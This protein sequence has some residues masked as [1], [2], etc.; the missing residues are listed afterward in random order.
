MPEELSTPRLTLRPLQLSDAARTQL[1]FPHWEIV[2]FLSAVVPWPFPQD[3]AMKYYREQA[4]PA[5]E[6]GDEWHWT[7]RLKGSPEEHI[8]AI[9][10]FRG[11]WDNRGFWMGMPWQGQ[12]LMTE[13]VAA[14]SEYWF[15]TLGFDRLR[16]PKAL[17]NVGSARISEKTGMRVIAECEREYVSGRLPS[18]IWEITA[19]EWRRQRATLG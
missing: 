18:R 6:R 7:I 17:A 10:L 11:E 15:G 8:G 13:A 5:I 14:A 1:L 16:A 3:G 2:R 12:G 4:L 19:E 9:S